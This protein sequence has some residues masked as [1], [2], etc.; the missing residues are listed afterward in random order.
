M[1]T[2]TVVGQFPRNA[3]QA[4][5][6]GEPWVV[7]SRHRDTPRGRGNALRSANAYAAEYSMTHGNGAAC[8]TEIRQGSAAL[9]RDALENEVEDR[10]IQRD[11]LAERY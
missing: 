4:V 2:L 7:L 1:Q 3:Y 11:M 6:D 5:P 10:A 9:D 8:R